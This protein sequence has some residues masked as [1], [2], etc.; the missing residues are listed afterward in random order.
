M[1]LLL[2]P[3]SADNIMLTRCARLWGISRLRAMACRSSRCSVFSVSGD[4]GRAMRSIGSDEK[5]ILSDIFQGVG[6]STK[7]HGSA[8]HGPM[9]RLDGA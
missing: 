4:N 1:A 5:M 7:I 6:T 8:F 2:S 3:A 9:V